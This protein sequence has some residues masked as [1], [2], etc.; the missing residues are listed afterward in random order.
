[1]QESKKW[2][3]SWE[4]FTVRSFYSVT[5]SRQAILAIHREKEKFNQG[6]VFSFCLWLISANLDFA[7]TL[8][9]GTKF[10]CM[11]H[12]SAHCQN[13]HAYRDVSLD[14]L[15]AICVCVCAST[16]SVSNSLSSTIYLVTMIFKLGVL[17]HFF[18]KCCHPLLSQILLS[19]LFLKCFTWICIKN[20]RFRLVVNF[21]LFLIF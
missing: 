20:H 4:I 21:V 2:K 10:V 18:K 13:L 17:E 8:S 14:Q 6:F 7:S 3:V 16:S 9:K 1:M 11:C 12:F 19:L 15:K 5:V